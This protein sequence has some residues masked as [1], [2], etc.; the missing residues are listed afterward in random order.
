MGSQLTT[1]TTQEGQLGGEKD[2]D[3]EEL[4]RTKAFEKGVLALPGTIFWPLG[5]K[6]AY[7]RAAFSVLDEADV[8]EAL[9]RLKEAILDAKENQK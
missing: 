5:R 7:V 1:I 3:S 2:G 4:V 8:N 9:R 6:T